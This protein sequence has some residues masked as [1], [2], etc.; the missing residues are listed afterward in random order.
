MFR[1]PLYTLRETFSDRNDPGGP[2]DT[3]F[4]TN[5]GNEI[6]QEIINNLNKSQRSGVLCFVGLFLAVVHTIDMY[7]MLPAGSA[8]RRLVQDQNATIP[9]DAVEPQPNQVNG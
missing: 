1:F 5:I 2:P 4:V 8:A 3:H 7:L 9:M 6:G